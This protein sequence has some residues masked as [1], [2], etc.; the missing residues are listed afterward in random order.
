[1]FWFNI[2]DNILSYS[3]FKIKVLGCNHYI[4]NINILKQLPQR[5]RCTFSALVVQY[6]RHNHKTQTYVPISMVKFSSVQNPFSYGHSYV[7]VTFNS[8]YRLMKDVR[9]GYCITKSF[10]KTLGNK[11]S[12]HFFTWVGRTT[13]ATPIM[14][15]I[16]NCDGQI[17]GTKSP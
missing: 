6:T 4:F 9:I 8:S 5:L 13:N 11:H 7:H 10:K 17:S 1:M 3:S 2:R 12:S 15:T 14:I 16:N